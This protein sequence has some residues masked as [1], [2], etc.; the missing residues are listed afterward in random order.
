METMLSEEEVIELLKPLAMSENYIGNQLI[1]MMD[2][3]EKPIS[4]SKDTYTILVAQGESYKSNILIDEKDDLF[5][6]TSIE[7]K[8][9]YVAKIQKQFYKM[10]MKR[11]I[12]N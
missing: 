4:I 11:T 8:K 6:L 12:K 9:F 2:I 1:A 5:V 7:D 10:I 3:L